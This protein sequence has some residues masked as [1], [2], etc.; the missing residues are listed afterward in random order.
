M[1]GGKCFRLHHGR[2]LAYWVRLK[3]CHQNPQER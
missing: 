1:I 3:G 2:S